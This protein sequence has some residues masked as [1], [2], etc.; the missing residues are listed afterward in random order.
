MNA[1]LFLL[2][3]LCLG[4]V[5]ILLAPIR[6]A[7]GYSTLGRK[8]GE[9]ERDVRVFHNFADATANDNATPSSQFPGWTGL[10]LAI[11]KGFAEWGSRPHGDGSGDPI[12]GNV[13]GSGGANF[14]SMWTG[15]AMRVGSS[16]QNIVS[17]ISSCGGS[18]VLAY[19]EAPITDGWRI[20]FCDEWTWDD[21]P[22]SIP[23]SR[24]DIQGIMTHEYGHALGLGHSNVG[25]AT[26]WPSAGGGQTSLRSIDPDDIAGVQF[27][28]GVAAASKPVIVATVADTGAGTLTIH[29]SNFGPI[30]NEVWFTNASI[31]LPGGDAIVKVTGVLS[32]SGET[33]IT[34]AIPA[35][36]SP[37][38]VIVNKPGSNGNTLSNAF[39]TDLTGTFGTPP[40]PSPSIAVITPS[41]IDALIPGQDQTITISG[42]NLD[43]TTALLLDG[44]AID[45]VRYTLV[46][47]TTITLDMPQAS[48]L[49]LHTLA[50][51][52]GSVTD[53]FDVTIVAPATPKY[54]VG[55][56]APLNVIDR[57]DGLVFRLAGT[58]GRSHKVLASTSPLPSV[59]P[60]IIS[61]DLGNNFQNL[62]EGHLFV[63][64]P[65]G[66]LEVL[67]PT[68]SLFD[69]GPS[70]TTVY[71]QTYEAALPYP[72]EV[73]NLQSNVL[74]Q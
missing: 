54:E 71:S 37:G 39:P 47:A 28:Y 11:W 66:W 13:I 23:G 24:F 57:D 5:A 35:G 10:E 72:L 25:S 53:G 58:P 46:N 55:T 73:S 67:I 34:V 74:V 33:V 38:D 36:A 52:D 20:R 17:A 12:G 61:L 3:T 62:R 31:T 56:G 68:E 41:T 59:L 50:V 1:K 60:G 30:N 29:G 9:N 2:P 19:T 32:S 65:S 16:G 21:G 4:A 22:G 7:A 42:T 63:I 69:P 8:L 27:L 6:P 45:P 14:D 64:P 51:T 26:M 70:G 18:G 15:N 48:S 44:G 43:L 49:G 40:P